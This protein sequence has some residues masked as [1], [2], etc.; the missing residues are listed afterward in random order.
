MSSLNQHINISTYTRTQWYH[1]TNLIALMFLILSHSPHP[2]VV[3]SPTL[4]VYRFPLGTFLTSSAIF[5]RCDDP[6]PYGVLQ[7][8]SEPQL[9]ARHEKRRPRMQPTDH[10]RQVHV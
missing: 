8:V 4:V 3:G 5:A 2:V 10:H 9:P 7:R 1:S 6:T